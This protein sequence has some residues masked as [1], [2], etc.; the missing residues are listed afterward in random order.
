MCLEELDSYIFNVSPRISAAKVQVSPNMDKLTE[1]L[2]RK[3]KMVN[4][5][6]IQQAEALEVMAEVLSIINGVENS[7]HNAILIRKYIA[8]DSLEDIAEAL[9]FEYS[10][11]TRLH[12]RAIDSVK[13]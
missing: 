8:G 13:I 11:M 3:E 2:A 6:N 5:L 12:K 4:R 7:L 1:L 9:G 10:W